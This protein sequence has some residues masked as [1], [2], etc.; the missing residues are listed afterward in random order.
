MTLAIDGT[1]DI[2]TEDWEHFVMGG[3]YTAKNRS[4]AAVYHSEKEYFDALLRLPPGTYWAHN[5][6][7]FDSI[8]LVKMLIRAEIPWTGALRG[9]SIIEVVVGGK[10]GLHFRD[11]FAAFPEKL[12][13]V[14]ATGGATKL[15]TGLECICNLGC[16]AYC[17]RQGV[18]CKCPRTCGGYC[19]IKRKM[20]PEKRRL[21]ADY[22]VGDCEGL[23]NGLVALASYC[24]REEIELRPTVGASAWAT[25]AKWLGLDTKKP[26]HTI[27]LYHALRAAYFGGRTE[28]YILEAP[29]GHRHDI[30]NAYTAAL[31]TICLPVGDIRSA[32]PG[33]AYLNGFDGV[34]TARV[35][36]P[37]CHIPPLPI[38]TPQRLAYCFG[39]FEGTWTGIALRYAEECGAKIESIS[40]GIYCEKSEPVLK[41]YADRMWGKR[42]RAKKEEP[43]GIYRQV[44]WL[45]NSL[46]GK[47]AM[48]PTVVTLACVPEDDGMKPGE[49]RILAENGML[50]VGRETERVSSC[51]HSEWAAHLTSYNGTEHHRQLSLAGTGAIYGDTDSVYSIDKLDRRAGDELGEWGYEGEMVEWECLAPKIY[52]YWDVAKQKYETRGKGMSR[53]TPVGFDKLKAGGSW[54]VDAGVFS[55]KTAIQKKQGIFKK[56]HLSRRLVPRAGDLMGSRRVE[57]K[58]TRAL[59]FDEYL[60]ASAGEPG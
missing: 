3:I 40:E 26:A 6:G 15:E 9:S 57:G 34:Y 11:S 58:S 7:K 35:T 5:G 4:G 50:V 32:N 19:A 21:V 27:A 47:L 17:A 41:P 49:T 37:E 24:D 22:L 36:V 48:T 2:E 8:W 38:R 18:E 39:T 29:R 12:S 13:I 59:S 25:C 51:A 30:H 23:Y 56:K 60:L 53:L 44:K 1:W 45:S 31:S 52:R 43:D 46:T 28:D 54:D 42:A 16:V 55:L 33:R 10:D 20:P 14:A